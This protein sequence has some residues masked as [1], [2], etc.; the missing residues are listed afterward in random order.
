[1]LFSGTNGQANVNLYDIT[2]KLVL[3]QAINGTATINTSSLSEGVYNLN[4]ISDEGTANKK[5]II[6]K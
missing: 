4:I 1:V 6:I 2:G 3:S 5:V